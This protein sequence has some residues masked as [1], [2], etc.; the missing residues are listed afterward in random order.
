M[1]MRT[2]FAIASLVCA[3]AVVAGEVPSDATATQ[4]AAETAPVSQRTESPALEGLGR[5][6]SF[7]GQAGGAFATRAAGADSPGGPDDAAED[8]A[9]NAP[10]WVFLLWYMGSR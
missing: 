3:A 2:V 5:P 1:P 10:F 6:V 8:E 4:P 7:G 9:L